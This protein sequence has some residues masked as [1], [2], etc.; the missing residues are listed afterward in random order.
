MG[1]IHTMSSEQIRGNYDIWRRFLTV[2]R[3]AAAGHG[4]LRISSRLCRRYLFTSFFGTEGKGLRL[5]FGS[6][7]QNLDDSTRF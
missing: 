2:A 7:I 4:W 3:N 1:H 5:L 6:L